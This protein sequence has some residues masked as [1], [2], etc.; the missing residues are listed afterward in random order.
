MKRPCLDCGR[1]ANKSRC[2]I[3][4]SVRNRTNPYLRPEWRKVA[5]A[6]TARDGRCVRCGSTHYLSAHHVIPRA[7]GG[8]DTPENLVSLCASCHGRLEAEQ[9]A[10]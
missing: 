5:R 2:R 9:R 7:Q 10:S 3:C 6:V 8:P 1:L 4:L